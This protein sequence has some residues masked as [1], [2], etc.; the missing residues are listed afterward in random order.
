MRKMR[1]IIDIRL[2]SNVTRRLMIIS[3]VLFLVSLA[4]I[5]AASNLPNEVEETMTVLNY[6]HQGR[7]DYLVHQ[8]A[9]YLF[10][11]ILLETNETPKT[12]EIP[13]TNETEEIPESPPSTPKYPSEI[14]DRFF[15]TFT[16]GF[17]PDQENLVTKVSQEVEVKAVLDK[18]DEEP[19]EVI[20]VPKTTQTESFSVEFSLDASNLAASSTTIITADVYATVETTD[21]DPIFESFTQSLTIRSNGSL[22]EVDKDL[23]STQRAS[24]GK[25]SYEQIG[26]FDYFVRLKGTSPWG[27][28][29][30]RPPQPPPPPPPPPPPAPP[31]P[32]LSSKTLRPGETI[33]PKLVDKMDATF[34]Y[35]LKSDRPLSEVA[36][37]VEITAILQASELWSKRFPLLYAE[38]SG[39]FKVSFS[40][41]L[42]HYLESLEAIRAETGASA[43]SYSLTIIA[44]VH[45]VAET[46]FEPIN[47]VFS[48]TLSSTLGGGTLEWNEELTKNQPSSIQETKLVPNSNRYLGLSVSGVRT[49]SVTVAAIL[50][51][52]FAFSVVLYVR[53]EP[54]ELSPIEEEALRIRKKYGELMAEATGHTPITSEK[55]ISLGSMEDLIK[56]ADELSKPIIHQTPS[57]TEEQHAYY[58]FDGSTRYEYLPTFSKK[59]QGSNA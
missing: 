18:P 14:T 37:D 22:L 31:P 8:K 40:L 56:I 1:P 12:N 26:Q 4:G 42:A 13:E 47:E 49:L 32:T 57:T 27:P 23:T 52:F 51:L 11:D 30:I 38:E 6:E 55:I 54:T 43:E 50:F 34:Y 5:L 25:L 45:T 9:T 17:V 29:A 28:I 35:R 39:N 58:V 36:A 46:E 16:Y 10:G 2:A 21:T 24:F 15:M 20:L 59:E 41:D 19:I 44:D 7:F 48:Q 33:F 3:A 53:S